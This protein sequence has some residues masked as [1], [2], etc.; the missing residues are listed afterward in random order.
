MRTFQQRNYQQAIA[1]SREILSA[2]P[3][4]PKARWL[5]GMSY[6]SLGDY[7]NCISDLV[8]AI[9]LGEKVELPIQRHGSAD[10]MK[11]NDGLTPGV[12]TI[13]KDLLQFQV[14]YTSSPVFSVP[15]AKVYR[16]TLEE[17]NRGGRVQV[18]VG[19]P[20][21]TKDSGK[22]YDFHP[23]QAGIRQV[24]FGTSTAFRI[25]CDNCLPAVRAIYQI[26]L[27]VKSSSEAGGSV[28]P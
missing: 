6:F 19:N 26:L 12:L 16:V 25:Y 14:S 7:N 1:I 24:V 28:K 22:D 8:K 17:N 20:N 10:L 18:K 13:G 27:Q 5:L 11:V 21:K 15:F 23:I 9:S 4:E 3:D 2:K